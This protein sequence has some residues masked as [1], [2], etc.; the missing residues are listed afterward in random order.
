MAELV[1]VFGELNGGVTYAQPNAGQP[2]LEAG[3]TVYDETPEHFAAVVAD[4]PGARRRDRRRL[5]RHDAR[6]HRRARRG[7]RPQR[8][9]PRLCGRCPTLAVF[10]CVVSAPCS[11]AVADYCE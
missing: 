3:E 11:T 10:A 1:P 8:R 6:L 5:L 2:R 4:V 9:R 7:A